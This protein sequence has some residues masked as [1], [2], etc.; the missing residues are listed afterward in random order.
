M[1]C[2]TSPRSSG[3]TLSRNALSRTRIFTHVVRFPRADVNSR[4]RSAKWRFRA[5]QTADRER[6]E[7]N[8]S[9]GIV[10]RQ[11]ARR[12]CVATKNARAA[13]FFHG[14][15]VHNLLLRGPR[16]FAR[17][18]VRIADDEDARAGSANAESG[19]VYFQRGKEVRAKSTFEGLR[20]E[21]TP[22]NETRKYQ[23]Y[24]ML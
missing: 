23:Q 7:S 12:S 5:K 8:A 6:Q 21:N 4:E 15:W 18:T 9:G 19:S 1:K 20:L 3:P 14:K 11:A 2:W 16:K 24:E 13:P 22:G 10:E 17:E